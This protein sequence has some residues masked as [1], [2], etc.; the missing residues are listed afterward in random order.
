[1]ARLYNFPT[2]GWT[3]QCERY[4]LGSVKD[5]CRQERGIAWK[6][7][8]SGSSLPLIFCIHVR[9]GPIYWGI[10]YLAKKL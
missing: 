6:A 9:Y 7:A 10:I 8:A 3:E 2:V 1:M 5:L 4:C